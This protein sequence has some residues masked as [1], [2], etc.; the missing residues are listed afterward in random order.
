MRGVTRAAAAVLAAATSLTVLTGCTGRGGDDGPSQ[1]VDVPDATEELDSY[2]DVIFA[3]EPGAP[4]PAALRYEEVLAECMAEAGFEYVP[5]RTAGTGGW[6]VA[7]GME[8]P[9]PEA[10]DYGYGFSLEGPDGAPP[11]LWQE[12]V[13]SETYQ[14]N[15]AYRLAL[16][17]EAQVAYGLAMDG[18]YSEH[19]PFFDQ[20]IAGE[21]EYDLSRAGCSGR[22]S[23]E[24]YPDGAAGPAELAEVK[25]AVNGM[26]ARLQEDSRVRETLP[27]WSTCMQ[28]AGYDGMTEIIDAVNSLTVVFED[29]QNTYADATPGHTGVTDLEVVKESI[30]DALQ[31]LQDTEVALAVADATCRE[32][33]GYVAAYLEAENDIAQEIL[34]TYRAD[35]DTWVAWVQEQQAQ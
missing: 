19:S 10:E 27:A 8:G 35:L 31:E 22:A 25:E 15:E 26:W 12:A 20:F 3:V 32:V 1:A 28:D 23:Q 21:L 11:D 6:S 18:D 17:P 5:D 34:D 29:W 30:P 33:S 7:L 4:N 2:L 14:A 16:S 13:Q 24:A 9:F